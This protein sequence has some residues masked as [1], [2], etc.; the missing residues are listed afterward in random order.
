MKVLNEE[1]GGVNQ[2]YIRDGLR[3]ESAKRRN[4]VE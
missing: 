3:D 2:V 4:K 1:E